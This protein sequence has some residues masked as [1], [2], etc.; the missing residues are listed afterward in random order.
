MT[1][2]ILVAAFAEEE[3]RCRRISFGVRPMET[4]PGASDAGPVCVSRWTCNAHE[5]M[6]VRGTSIVTFKPTRASQRW[7]SHAPKTCSVH[8]KNIAI[9]ALIGANQQVDRS[10][11]RALETISVLDASIAIATPTRA[12]RTK[13]V[14]GADM[15]PAVPQMSI[16]TDPP[17]LVN[18]NK[19]IPLQD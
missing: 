6:N 19:V 14:V 4:V 7:S 18:S 8:G 5:T 11:S 12:N 1:V 15:T 2:R 17:T 3:A 13:V 16:A 9:F 10:S